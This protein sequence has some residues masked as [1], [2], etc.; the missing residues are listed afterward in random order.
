MENPNL[1]PNQVAALAQFEKA[2][3]INQT[4]N[5]P[6]YKDILDLLEARV[7]Q[8]EADLM[9]AKYADER[10]VLCLQKRSQAMRDLFHGWQL[11][12]AAEIASIDQ[13]RNQIA[14]TPVGVPGAEF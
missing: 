10:I 7:A 4:V 6:G 1:S 14:S 12:I 5:T 3:R 9:N 8:A 13:L 2:H 11:D